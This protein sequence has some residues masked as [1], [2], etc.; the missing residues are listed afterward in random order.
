MVVAEDDTVQGNPIREL[1]RRYV[2]AME[3]WQI[4]LALARLGRFGVPREAWED[5]MQELVV[6]ILGFRYD[7]ARAGGASEETILCR[8]LDNRIRT[9]ARSNAR[10]RAMLDRVGEM[11]QPLEDDRDPDQ[12][13]MPEAVRDAIATLTP[14]QQRICRALMAGESVHHFARRTGLHYESVCRQVRRIGRAF[15]DRGLAPW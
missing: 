14:R 12:A 11:S 6:E 9:L 13:L 15:A 1:Y 3:D 4:K 5:A 2:G 10:R 8:I 7:P